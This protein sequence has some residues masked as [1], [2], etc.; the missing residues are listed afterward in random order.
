[1]VCPKLPRCPAGEPTT[2]M[3]PPSPC[4]RRRIAAAR[5]HTNVPRMCTAITSSKSSSLIFHSTRSRST[6]ALVTITSRRPK[7]ST[8]SDT[9]SCAHAVSATEPDCATACPPAPTI[10]SAVSLEA[11]P[12]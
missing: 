3:R 9:I 8:A 7:C 10:S 2:M 11:A 5:A 1:L 6:P 12:S 4:S